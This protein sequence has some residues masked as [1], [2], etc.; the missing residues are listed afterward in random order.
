MT[1]I[2][3]W[4]YVRTEGTWCDFCEK[5][6]LRK[7]GICCG[8]RGAG[9]GYFRQINILGFIPYFSVLCNS[10]EIHNEAFFFAC[11]FFPTRV[12]T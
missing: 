2:W 11:G 10:S 8:S 9:L 12:S 1:R 5:K 4:A 3:F 7:K 6:K